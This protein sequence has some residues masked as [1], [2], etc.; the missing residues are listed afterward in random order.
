MTEESTNNQEY[1]RKTV[2]KGGVLGLMALRAQGGNLG[3]SGDF[4]ATYLL[5]RSSQINAEAL[6]QE[7][8]AELEKIESQT[9]FWH[10]TGRY[11]YKNGKKADVLKSITVSG[12]LIPHFDDID[13]VGKMD[14]IS[15]ARSRIYA[16]AYAD[17]HATEFQT[18]RHGDSL[19]WAS[20]FIGPLALKIVQETEY[21]KPESRRQ[22]NEHFQNSSSADWYQ[23]VRTERTGTLGIFAYGSDIEGNYP[24]IF[25]IKNGVA[26][27]AD[28]S[29]SVAVHEARALNPI[30]FDNM[31]HIEVPRDNIKETAELLAES[32]IEIPVYSIEDFEALAYNHSFTRIV[33]Q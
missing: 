15:L 29:Q 19:L 25:G 1:S 16:R 3:K 4:L 9:Q 27:L 33:G 14:S 28:T 6:S 10:G 11:Q 7:R 32:G 22:V 17:M 23:K 13:L 2:L 30:T 26:E 12:G 24:I 31:T 18:E 21:W 20:A 5:R 8:R